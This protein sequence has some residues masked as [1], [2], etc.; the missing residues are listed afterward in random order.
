MGKKREGLVISLFFLLLMVTIPTG[1]L[2]QIETRLSS[3]G[4][5]N[6]QILGNERRSYIVNTVEQGTS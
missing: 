3:S 1:N 5:Y 6:V 4:P 2:I